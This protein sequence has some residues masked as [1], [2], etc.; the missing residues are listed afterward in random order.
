MQSMN[1]ISSNTLDE[2]KKGFCKQYKLQAS[3]EQG[4]TSEFTIH[5]LQVNL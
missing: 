1:L 5:K 4:I 2:K 3:N